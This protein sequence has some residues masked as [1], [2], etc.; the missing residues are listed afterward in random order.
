MA[1]VAQVVRGFMERGGGHWYPIILLTGSRG[2]GKTHALDDLAGQ[3]DGDVPYMYVDCATVKG[4]ARGLLTKLVFELNL[5]SGAYG[6]LP[7]PRLVAGL[8]AMAENLGPDGGDRARLQLGIAFE[9]YNDPDLLRAAVQRLAADAVAVVPGGEDTP[10]VATIAQ[11]APELLLDGLLTGRW[12][13]KIDLGPG[14]DWYGHQ[15]LGLRHDPLRILAGLNDSAAQADTDG[16]Q[17]Q[18]VEL[19]CA[20]FLADLEAGFAGKKSWDVN[21][22][23]LL[24]NADENA[25]LDFLEAL[26]VT[27]NRRVAHAPGRPDPLTAVA[28]SRGKL[29]DRVMQSEEGIASLES[30][31]HRHYEQLRAGNLVDPG[32][33]PVR[34]PDLTEA[35]VR[36]LIAG[37]HLREAIGEPVAGMLHRFAQGHPG[38]TR[39]LVRA[40]ATAEQPASLAAV[41]DQ[42][43][44]A[45]EPR[46]EPGAGPQIGPAPGFGP[47]LRPAAAA[48]STVGGR[49]RRELIGTAGPAAV[50]D[51]V[52][53]AAARNLVDA[54]Q[55]AAGSGLCTTPRGTRQNE[56]FPAELWVSGPEHNVV[57]LPV[58]RNLLLRDLADRS[59]DWTKALTWLCDNSTAAGDT[60][61][62]LYYSL[63][64]GDTQ[65][66]ARGLH[67][68]LKTVT[69]AQGAHAWLRLLHTVTE[70]PCESGLD[71]AEIWIDPGDQ[72]TLT[73]TVGRLVTALWLANNFADA[74][75]LQGLY[76][77]AAVNLDDIAPHSKG[78][79]MVLRAQAE[80]YRRTS[81][82]S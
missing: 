70:A 20:A 48:R 73:A 31:G 54:S 50:R 26:A 67:E 19:L 39:L 44:P 36:N 6:T 66:V 61:A 37:A 82:A 14:R 71:P 1:D 33:Y 75:E 3:L 59:A 40:L 56:V 69:G 63:A 47:G 79:W 13:R 22:G 81:T 46:P 72:P 35:E 42:P 76:Q 16:S 62:V 8:L 18:V 53:C 11:Y 27:R 64:L 52:F 51:L 60:E 4:G 21:C 65:G 49:L 30:A 5:G 57:M 38:A 80:K 68:Q 15:D 2:C 43:E 78:G 34:L 74:D 41:L 9:E 28:G 29:V 17:R 7:F 25:G 24:D 45:P 12:N 58:L 77:E 32:W 55:L 23:V 10:G